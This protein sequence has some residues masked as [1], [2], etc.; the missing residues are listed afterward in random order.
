MKALAFHSRG[1]NKDA[2]DLTYVLQNY[3]GRAEAVAKRLAPLREADEARQ[4][5]QELDRDFAS[6]DSLGP[7]RVSEFL[8]GARDD[9]A[10]A[11][12]WGAVRDLIEKLG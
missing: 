10:E 12:A 2:Y 3:E 8:L 4:A 1:E 6:V 7:V 11:D 5:L 9:A